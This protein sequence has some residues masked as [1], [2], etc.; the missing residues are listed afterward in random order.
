MCRRPQFHLRNC[1][2]PLLVQCISFLKLSS[3]LWI[4]DI[5]DQR[6]CLACGLFHSQ[7]ASYYLIDIRP[8][9][10]HEKCIQG[11]HVKS[12]LAHGVCGD[13]NRA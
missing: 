9:C 10:C 1:I 5:E 3:E 2:V 8:G 13:E 11:G 7:N 6:M 12:L 4:H